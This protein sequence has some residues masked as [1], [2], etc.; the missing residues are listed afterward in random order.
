MVVVTGGA[1]FI[2]SVFIWKLNKEGEDRIL[3]VDSFSDT[4]SHSK[5]R[6]LVGLE[7]YDVI[8]KNDFFDVVQ[9]MKVDVIFHFGAKTSTTEKNFGLVLKE[10]YEFSKKLFLFALS[11]NIR[12]VYASS[13]ATYGAGEKGFD[14]DEEKLPELTPLN[15]Y[16]FSK[17]LFDLWLWKNNYLNYAL[18]LKFFNVFGPNEYHKGEMRSFISKAYEQIV[19][20]GKVRLFKSFVPEIPDG[21]Q[22]RDFIYVFDVVDIVFYLFEKGK[23]G[24]FNVGTGKAHSFNFVVESTF[25]SLGLKPKIEYFDM[26]EDIKKQY[27]NFTQ[28]NIKKLEESGYDV[29][30]IQNIKEKIQDYVKKYLVPGMKTVGEVLR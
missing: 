19:N 7:F 13:A 16:A 22:K 30:K 1:G 29:S 27:Q 10:N 5:W 20:Y 24:V 17:H 8:D 6:N 14:D 2:G 18:G 28:A 3:V 9:S 25:S 11:R 26:P 4:N 12:F 23:T 15:P 21:E